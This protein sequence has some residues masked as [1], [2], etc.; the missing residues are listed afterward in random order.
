MMVF[1]TANSLYA[2]YYMHCNTDVIPQQASFLLH[3]TP[4]LTALIVDVA[5]YTPKYT[6]TIHT[7]LDSDIKIYTCTVQRPTTS[8]C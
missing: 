2:L 1:N 6:I 5:W 3:Q 7:E 4:I 8:I